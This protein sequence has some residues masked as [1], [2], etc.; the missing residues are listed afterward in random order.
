MKFKHA[1]YLERKIQRIVHRWV[2]Q[3]CIS[4]NFKQTQMLMSV[5]VY[6]N[7]FIQDF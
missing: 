7:R 4:K 3:F 5:K 2:N 6:K 1:F